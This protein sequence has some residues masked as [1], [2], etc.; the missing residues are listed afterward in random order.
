[1]PRFFI[2]RPVF[3]WVVSLFIVLFGVLAIRRLPVERYP[4]VAPPAV[5]I[6]A[7]YPGATPSTMSDSVLAPIEREISGVPH[8]LYFESSSDTSGV[9]QIT[10]TFEPGTDP[11]LAQVAVQ[12]RLRTVEPRLPQMVRQIGLAVEASTSNFLLIVDLRSPSGRYDEQTLGDFLSRNLVEELKRIPGVGRVQVFTA[13]RALRVWLDPVQ[14]T[15]LGVSIDDVANAIRA[16]NAQV[17]P[18]RVGDAPTVPGQRVTIPL[19]V[20]GELETPEQF[21]DVVLRAR[22]D[23][24]RV[25]LRDVARIE[26]GAQSYGTATRTD[27]T[28][29]AGAGVMLSPGA[30][31]VE[32]ATLVRERVAEL[33]ET[34]PDGIE[35]SVPYDTAPFV[36]VS[37]EKVLETFV[38]AMVLVFAVMFL[39]LQS[40][41]YT[42]VPAIVA[43]IALLGT[44]AV[45]YAAGFSINVL[46]MFGMVL[47]IGII[48]D[49]AIVV[50]EN[51]ER[52]MAT[53]KLSPKE[54]TKKAMDEI[55]G[56]VIGITLVLSA[57]FIPMAFA[58]GSVGTIY[59]QFSLSMAVS[60]LLSAFLAL[61]LTP[62]LCATLLKPVSEHHDPNRGAFGPFNRAF[63]WL[64]ERYGAG[65]ARIVRRSSIG[66]VALLA[67]SVGAGWLFR[68]LPGSF[69]PEEDQGYWISSVALPSD[70]TAER[71]DRVI[72]SY[73][74]YAQAR[75]G[76]RSVVAI[77][78]FGFSGS[79][80]N[81]AL[82]FTILD[83][84]DAREGA[85]A[86][87]EVA[88]ANAA[89]AGLRDGMMFHVVPPSID[90]LG[91]SAG[92]AMRLVDRRNQGQQALL[93][94][95][96]QILAAAAE[97]SVVQAVYPEGLPDG[98][99]VRLEVDRHS[100]EALGVSFAS[101]NATLSAALGSMYVND[102]PNAGRLQQVILQAEPQ[103][104]MQLDDVLALPVRNQEG[105]MVP[106][107][108]VA[109]AR[110]ER[111]PLQLVR[112]NGYPAVRIAGAAAPGFSSGEAM[113]EMERLAAQLPPGFGVE[114]TGLSFQ[115][116]LSGDEA[117]ALLALSL[118]VVFLVLAALYESWS[119]PLSVILVVPLGVLGALLAVTMRGMPNDVFFKVGLITL[120]GL[121]AKNAIL[122][123]EFA[124]QLED[125][126]RS[127]TDAAIE[128]AKLRLRPILMTSLA[129][130]LGVVP[131][132]IA[133]GAS[134]ETQR[135]IGT[136]V[137]GG[138]ISAT[139]L[140]VV[141]V[142]AFYVA[143]RKVVTRGKRAAAEPSTS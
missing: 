131:L 62:A 45:M 27:G 52:L 6:T 71:T 24:S 123:V 107:S 28:A 69:L 10:A 96:G 132:A 95:Q 128:A 140:A 99:S 127:V 137:L 114:W 43:P 35:A 141:L 55:T 103:A 85:T 98:A 102:F 64:T 78:G 89:F 90:S 50:V 8:L 111:S 31:A 87:G 23:G 42:L 47:A 74:E 130:T 94:A 84:W 11:E 12:N 82:M 105:R 75:P 115:E 66:I 15:A 20:Q 135:A 133:T 26:L 104:R 97:S 91:T 79:G 48:V 86:Q 73:E 88:S 40:V 134:A 60:I 56:A 124:K 116:R 7:T 68:A 2:E 32:T 1:M 108:A 122:I 117:P 25:L 38:E 112:Y 70:A 139:V 126:G 100:A 17:S 129:F 58:S 36:R 59:R 39:F 4:T 83:D 92:F 34:L 101:I 119:I 81:A 93:A 53:E 63:T 29:S 120:I 13:P 21:G 61:S 121:S 118:L 3:A 142:P 106:L 16:Q 110:W 54:A 49:D 51:V 33:G 44:F 76:V 113:A 143:V 67:V 19:V 22:P 37:I 5:T 80:P 109:T 77:R 14:L 9:A 57:V 138:M 30:N 41:R 65:V 72:R 46:T 18:G 136:G 125:E